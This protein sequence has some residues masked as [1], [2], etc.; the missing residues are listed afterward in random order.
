MKSWSNIIS[1][2]D[3]CYETSP[4]F[5]GRS[6]ATGAGSRRRRRPKRAAAGL[7][8]EGLWRSRPQ[9]LPE[10]V[11]GTQVPGAEEVYHREDSDHLR[12][13]LFPWPR[14]QG[15]PFP[16]RGGAEEV[17]GYRGR[18]FGAAADAVEEGFCADRVPLRP[19]LLLRTGGT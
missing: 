5:I 6:N 16:K 18:H 8:V 13:R 17:K 2:N 9:R 12:A 1:V 19:S 15:R 14:R 3:S 7:V 4:D 11:L 10:V